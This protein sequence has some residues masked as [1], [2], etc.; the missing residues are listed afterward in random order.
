M[1]QKK[2][3]YLHDNVMPCSTLI[4]L[5]KDQGWE[6]EADEA[7]KVVDDG[8]SSFAPSRVMVDLDIKP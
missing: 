8:L 5:L 3:L 4:K 1:C 7:K 2:S 6:E